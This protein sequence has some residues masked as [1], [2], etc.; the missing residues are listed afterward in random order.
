[1]WVSRILQKLALQIR[2]HIMLEELNT[3]L[4]EL[5]EEVEETWRHL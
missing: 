2:R 1:M 4:D 3:P 5:K